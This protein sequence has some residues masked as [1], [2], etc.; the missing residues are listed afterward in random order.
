MI[1]KEK[2]GETW[3]EGKIDQLE[4]KRK[5]LGLFEVKNKKKIKS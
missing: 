3:K 5:K 1:Y 4:N 2:K